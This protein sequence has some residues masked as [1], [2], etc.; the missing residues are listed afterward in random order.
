MQ[1][2][3]V[4]QC[5]IGACDAVRSVALAPSNSTPPGPGVS[6]RAA[7]VFVS[8]VARRRVRVSL[9][10]HEHMPVHGLVVFFFSFWKV[11]SS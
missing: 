8:C 10:W 11:Q 7:V 9:N 5:K 1:E 2:Q 6:A 4:C 3:V